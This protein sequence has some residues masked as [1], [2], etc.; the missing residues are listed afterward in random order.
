[1]EADFYQIEDLIS[2]VEHHKR[3]VEVKEKDDVHV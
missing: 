2:A 3:V 1:M